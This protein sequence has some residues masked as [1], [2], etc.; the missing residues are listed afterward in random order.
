MVM[1]VM[2]GITGGI[3]LALFFGNFLYKI[4]G[5][6]ILAPSLTFVAISLVLFL[7]LAIKYIP[8]DRAEEIKEENQLK[9]KT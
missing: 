4:N 1:L 8:D 2:Y 6:N 5:Y 3:S 7:P 9:A